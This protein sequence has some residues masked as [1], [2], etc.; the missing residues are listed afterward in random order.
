MISE[1]QIQTIVQNQRIFFHTGATLDYDF[2][3]KVLEDLKAGIKDREDRF[4]DALKQDLGKPAYEAYVTE[5]GF[6]LHELTKTMGQLKKWMRPKRKPTP[7]YL[8]PGSSRMVHSPLGVT[9]IIS[10]FNYPMQLCIAPL[11][12]ALAAGNTAVVKASELTPAVGKVLRDLVEDVFRPEHVAFV[13]GEVEETKL[14]LAQK[15][16]HIFFT[17]SPR[18]G[19]IV[20]AAAAKH[21]T[22]V[23]LELGGKSPCIVHSDAS[24]APA[25]RRIAYGKFM[26]AGQ[27]CIA[28][29]YVLV[30]QE[31]EQAFLDGMKQRI[32]SLYGENPSLSPD[33]GRI[34]NEGHFKRILSLIDPDKV[35]VGGTHDEGERFI[36]PTVMAGVTLEDRIMDEEI[37][38]PVLPVMTYTTLDQVREILAA[39]PQHPLALYL[40]T[41]SR[42]VSE[43]IMNGVSFGGGCVNHCIQHIVNPH[44]P[45]GGHGTSGM[46][47]YHGF[48][49][50]EQFSHKKGIFKAPP[51]GDLPL[52]YPPYKGKLKWMKAIFR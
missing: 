40:F 41:E 8:L 22:P 7:F 45:F 23:T 39:L 20:M 3:R 16:D 10:P 6:L 47:Q 52:I 31:A 15:F 4:R 12:A 32:L 48:H 46:G 28:P 17:G 30:H 44:L 11:I 33:L 38:G 19:G 25:I 13:P 1:H 14:L 51:W 42:E 26:N 34:V 18:V 9:L 50:F 36:A 27:T 49:G 43:E 35:V 29:D 24:L 2:R 37:F 21:L 5:T